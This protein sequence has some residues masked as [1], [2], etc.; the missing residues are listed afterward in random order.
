MESLRKIAGMDLIKVP[1][2]HLDGFQQEIRKNIYL[3]FFFKK[4][5]VLITPDYEYLATGET[6]TEEET[7]LEIILQ[8]KRGLMD[9]FKDYL[10]YDLCY[11]SA[12][13][14]TNSY[15]IT[16]NRNLLIA[17][18]VS[19]EDDPT[20]FIVKLYTI[21]RGDLPD[22]YGDKIYL[23][24]DRIS[25]KTTHRDHFALKYI[26]NSLIEQFLKLKE[27]MK[28]NLPDFEYSEMEKEYLSEMEETI[29]DFAEI[30]TEIQE[31]F[32]VEISSK[33]ME[34]EG[35][36]LANMQFRNLKHILIELDDSVREIQTRLFEMNY[37][38]A[39][40]YV[41]KFSKDVTND[42][43]FVMFKVNGRISDAI[44]RIHV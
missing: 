7:A 44:N 4:C 42:I 35:M 13:L 43:N 32:P 33:T 23:G 26:R 1:K 10:I 19:I 25:L 12:L 18:L 21:A 29:S 17:R 9:K 36:I 34:E 28:S 39:A 14:E 31:R 38:H 20:S 22:N 16:L 8:E 6:T 41:T 5:R 30:A 40:R 37:A 27:R 11:Y 2:I 24:R 15:Y 3:E